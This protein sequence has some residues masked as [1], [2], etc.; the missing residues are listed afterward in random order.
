MFGYGYNSSTM[1]T[2]KFVSTLNQIVTFQFSL[3]NEKA[4]SIMAAIL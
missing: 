3:I 2:T 4:L 1:T